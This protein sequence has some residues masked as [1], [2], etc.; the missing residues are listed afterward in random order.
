MNKLLIEEQARST[1]TIYQELT[2]PRLYL[3]STQA[4]WEGLVAQAFQEPREMKSWS[5]FP[6]GDIMLLLYAGGPIHAERRWPHGPW[7]GEDIYPG[8]MVLNWDKG[9]PYEIRWWSLSAFPTQALDIHLSRTLVNRV[10]QEVVGIDL[11]SLE[12]ARR[13]GI[14]DPL[15]SQIALSLWRELEQPA[16]AGKLYAQTA[17]QLLALHLVRHYTS[18]NGAP[19]ARHPRPQGLTERQV[20]QVQEFILAHLSEDLSLDRVARQIGL[21]V[22]HFA[23]SFRK[24]TGTSLHQVVLRQRIERAQGLLH[25]T[26]MSLTHIAKVCGFADQSHLTQVFKRHLGLTPHIYRHQRDDRRIVTMRAPA[27]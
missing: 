25:E 10:A 9:L 3:S 12:L 17:A 1:N 15:L 19:R 13:T 26:D 11:S 7:K 16:P 27:G 14:R 5:V 6:S 21:S 18:R 8:D 23:R 24:A 4:G 22:S 20:K 2:E